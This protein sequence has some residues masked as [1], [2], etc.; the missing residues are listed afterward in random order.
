MENSVQ[1]Y[2]KKMLSWVL[3]LFLHLI[4]YV[5]GL[6]WSVSYLEYMPDARKKNCIV[7]SL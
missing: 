4:R 6:W 5:N 2:W 3:V 7:V 1:G